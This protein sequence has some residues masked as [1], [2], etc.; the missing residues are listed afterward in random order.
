MQ[1]MFNAKQEEQ[2]VEAFQEFAV[3]RNQALQKFLNFH[4]SSMIALAVAGGMSLV[5]VLLLVLLE[6][7]FITQLFCGVSLAAFVVAG[8]RAVSGSYDFSDDALNEELT[9]VK[10]RML[11]EEFDFKFCE[12]DSA[13]VDL[14]KP[15]KYLVQTDDDE[16]IE[17]VVMFR[18]PE[19]MTF[20][21][22]SQSV[23]RYNYMQ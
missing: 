14:E 3:Q 13:T 19:G 15:R 4:L 12:L 23:S 17:A 16:Y 9:L 11:E 6:P 20:T 22:I 2:L 5:S 1:A 18:I 7:V 21:P 8:I 10:I